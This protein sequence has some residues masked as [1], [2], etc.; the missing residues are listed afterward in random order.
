MVLTSTKIVLGALLV[1]VASTPVAERDLTGVDPN[2]TR[3]GWFQKDASCPESNSSGYG[4]GIGSGGTETQRGLKV[5]VIELN[6]SVIRAGDK[7]NA[8]V[9]LVNA[10]KE[11]ILLP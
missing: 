9:E 3:H 11:D 1:L 5:G 8:L 6:P 4:A 7:L 2:P 10:S